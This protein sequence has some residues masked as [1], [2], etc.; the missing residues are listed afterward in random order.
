M[1]GKHFVL[2]LVLWM[3]LGL[4][5]TATPGHIVHS[6]NS[7][8]VAT[9]TDQTGNTFTLQNLLIS[10]NIESHTTKF[11][12]DSE[13][14]TTKAEFGPFKLFTQTRLDPNISTLSQTSNNVSTKS[15]EPATSRDQLGVTSLVTKVVT[16]PESDSSTKGSD[17][18]LPTSLL[19][20]PD[21]TTTFPK[22]TV[23]EITEPTNQ[24][25]ATTLDSTPPGSTAST[26]TNSTTTATVTERRFG[27]LTTPT[28]GHTTQMA[29]PET[30]VI[31]STPI[32]TTTISITTISATTT[33]KPIVLPTKSTHKKKTGNH[34]TVVAV[35]I[36]G[37]LILMI[38]CF[39]VIYIRKRRL[40]TKQLLNT[41]WAGPSPFLDGGVDDSC[42][43][44]QLRE[45]NRVSLAG[46]LPQRLST[47]LSLL[48]ETKEEFKMAD[49]QGS[50]FGREISTGE[51]KPSN[52]TNVAPE[53][54]QDQKA[55]SAN[56]AT[57]SSLTTPDH[58]ND[59]KTPPPT[60]EITSNSDNSDAPPPISLNDDPQPLMDIDLSQSSDNGN[61][62]PEKPVDTIL[63]P[64]LP[65]LIST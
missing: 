57:S 34:G 30:S 24:P 64:A 15:T 11:N 21:M 59:A 53:Q 65:M 19:Q 16:I 26:E 36:G 62:A 43:R 44:V 54:I 22:S 52:G 37:A 56:S 6:T 51:V 58:D 18:P 48:Q 7:W 25:P 63:P 4:N 20:V 49:T 27:D 32:S 38:I 28:E 55:P 14:K 61:P 33:K 8:S 40:R 13:Q 47:R 41:E 1:E 9:T 12:R 3:P 45:S 2:A 39:G 10:Q 23:Q 5:G 60:Q 17:T 31:V 42:G 50:T 29:I 35:L 46:F